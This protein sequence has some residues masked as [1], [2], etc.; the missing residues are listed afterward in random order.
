MSVPEQL[1]HYRIVAPL[2]K[3][4]MGEVFVAED[5]KLQRK[6]ALKV[7][8]ALMASD[9]E[10]RQRFEREAQ[11]VAALNHPN[12]VTIHSVEEDRGIPFLTM[13]LVEG[14]PLNEVMTAGP[15]AL[16]PL[17]RIGIAISDAIAAAHQRGI[18]H[19][20]LKPANVMVAPDGRVKV[21]DFGLAKLRE[22][23]LEGDAEDV[24]RMP[25][26]DLTGEGRIIGTVAY[27]SPEQAEGKPVDS[28]TDIFSLG[29]MLHEMATG[30][31]PFK[32]DTNMSVISSILKDTPSSITDVNPNLPAGLARV[33]RRALAKDASRRYQSATDLRNDL[34]ELKQEIDGGL[35]M[36]VHGMPVP[37]TSRANWPKRVL[38]LGLGAILLGAVAFGISKWMGAAPAA[39]ASVFEADRF[40]RLTS[41]GN[42]FLAT[43][44]PDGNYV[45]HIKNTGT[46]PSLWVRQTTT[47]SDVQIVP[48]APVRFDSVTYAPDATHVYYN[49]YSLTGG[50]ATL[51]KVP[52]L[53]GTPH[54]VLEDVDSRI[55]FSPDRKQFAFVRGAPARGTAY[56]MVANID[57]TDVRQLATLP[58]GELF[59]N[60]AVAWSPDGKTLLVPAQSA[61]DGPHQLVVAVDTATGTP[62]RLPG[63]WA[64]VGD[65]QWL[66]DGRSFGIAAAGFTGGGPQV[67]QVSYPSGDARRIT[68][69]LNNYI[70]VS[71]TAD[72]KSLVTVQAENVSN[73]WVAPA[74]DL[75]GGKQITTG[76]GRG[77]GQGGLAWTPDGRIVYG[78]V[79]SGKPE[80]WIADADGSN[81]RQLTTAEGASTQPSVTKDGRYIVFQRFIKN[82]AYLWRMG[83]DGSD[84]KQLTQGGV[85]TGPRAGTDFVYYTVAT[86]G[87]PKPWKVSINGGDP[88]AM[89][90][91]HFRPIDV[92]PDGKQLLGAG[93]DQTERRSVL[94]V[95]STA[96]GAPRPSRRFISAAVPGGIQTDGVWRFGAFTGGAFQLFSYTPGDKAP[97]AIAKSSDNVF[98]FAWAPDGKR[99]LIARGQNISDVVL[100]A[101]KAAER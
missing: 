19:R 95:M 42:A 87:S 55:S 86:S 32:G 60:F 52:V 74:T 73:L 83:L 92:S 82:G 66:P 58:Q 4:G 89:G 37:K 80:I 18:T 98:G 68:N 46:I 21:L 9:P 93:W 30:E 44:S 35:T 12:I 51:Y 71:F 56:L 84:P 29:V 8:S 88:V 43:I 23:Q 34:E 45:V 94:A 14:R 5:T 20:D 24:T 75:A 53:G 26:T 65:V 54:P 3:G 49:T 13:E 78:S 38:A 15:L 48:P 64:F 39:A 81:A 96:G 91:V 31:K 69:D 99:A 25:A 17:L 90:D 27:M 62:T 76:R 101:A 50:V 72:G 2:G 61:K 7:L 57:G 77:D 33:I 40:T 6:V 59:S 97:K 41:T 1:N 47:T 11:A 67:W 28:R 10:R 36:S 16:D 22:A 85:E 79:V 100:I 63:R 70:G